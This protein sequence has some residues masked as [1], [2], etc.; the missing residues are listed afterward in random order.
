VTKIELTKAADQDLVDIFD[1]GIEN[2][3]P[4]QAERYVAALRAKM[5]T[6]AENPSFGVNYDA[7]RDRVRRY[8]SVSHAIYYRIIDG[9]IRVIRVLH[10]RMDPGRHI[11]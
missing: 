3:G 11:P 6:V 8:E 2:F 5:A 10:G 1:Y 4:E 7:V 9:G